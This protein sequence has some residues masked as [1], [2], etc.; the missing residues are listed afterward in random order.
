M[1]TKLAVLLSTLA[2]L[3]APIVKAESKEEYDA[4]MKWFNE[5]R[6]GMFIHW[7]LYSAAAGEWEG[8]PVKYIGEWIQS[9]A[10]IPYTQYRS[11]L[12]EKF[13]PAKYDP[14]AWV[15][16]AK[17]AGVKYIVITTKHHDGFCLWDSALTDWDIMSTPHKKDLL[18]PLAD[19]CAKHG[20]RFCAYHS[21]MDWYHPDWGS[22]V[23]KEGVN[24]TWRGN[25]EN[26]NPDMDRFTAYLKGQLKEVIDNYNPGILWFDGEWED[27]WTHE[28]GKDL[29]AYLRELDPKLIINNRVDKGRAGMQGHTIDP[30]FK[31]DYG[32]PEQEIPATGFGEGVAWE[33]CMTM[34]DTWGFK[35]DDHNWKS[36]EVLVRNLIDTA[37]KGGNYLLNVGPTAE[38]EI[39]TPSLERLAAI[40]AWM[41]TS[42]ESIYGT[43]ASLF[44][45]VSWDG[46][47]TTRHNADGTTTVYLHVF[48]RPEGGKLIIKDL[49]TR[50]EKAA[51]RGH[52]SM[53]EI[54][55]T[56]GE[57]TIQLPE[58][59][60]DPIAAVVSLSFKERP[61]I[62]AARQP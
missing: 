8:K 53:L 36:S 54:S 41:K 18:K 60:L 27:A 48:Q 16:A 12:Q 37:S 10:R 56:A 25:W 45:K 13:N 31:G 42:G 55:G 34:N 40:G 7:G 57:W 28:R 62:K 59:P 26:P 19:A 4:R 44:P 9:F 11:V 23:S 43:T 32:T 5:A 35:K 50:P 58:G 29:Y 52:E 20:I 47:S 14:E 49:V 21:I 38:G 22:K 15:V 6:F 30:K 33:S 51:L 3:A 1:K 39:P 24:E 61:E 46:R 17:E 2:L